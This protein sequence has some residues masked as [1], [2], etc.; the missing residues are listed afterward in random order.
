T[1][2]G[3]LYSRQANGSGNAELIWETEGS[4]QPEDWSPDGRYI[5]ANRST[6]DGGYDLWILPVSGDEEPYGLVTS[7]FDVGYARFSPDGE[8]LAYLSNESGQYEMY[9]TRF[10]GGEGKW[11]VSANG[12]DWVVGWKRDGSEIYFMDP[13]GKVAAV[14][15]RLG[16]GVVAD[17][18]QTLFPTQSNDT[19][20]AAGSGEKFLVAAP[21]S[22]ERNFPITLVIN[23][24][25]SR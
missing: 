2:S 18:P 14:Q 23:W 3:D 8:W 9:V 21:E 5:A 20:A 10:P 7:D 15:V 17:L 13:E 25:A 19:W 22:T 4:A 6:A 16:E 12:A 11:Q 1:S 24:L